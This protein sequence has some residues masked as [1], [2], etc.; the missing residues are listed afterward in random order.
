MSPQPAAATKQ[1]ARAML[2]DVALE[3]LDDLDRVAIDVSTHVSQLQDAPAAL[4][5]STYL[6]VLHRSTS[7]NIGAVMSSL[8]YGID[9][10]SVSPPHGA[11]E[12]VDHVACDR[13]GLPVLLRIYRLGAAQTAHYFLRCL[14]QRVSDTETLAALVLTA[15]KHLDDYVDHVM[16]CLSDQWADRSRE[17][18]R[19]GLHQDAVIRAVIAGDATNIKTLDYPFSGHHVA[20]A[21]RPCT[22]RAATHAQIIASI[23]RRF[24]G[25]PTITLNDHRGSDMVWIAFSDPPPRARIEATV[26]DLASQLFVAASDTAPGVEGF[27]T[28]TLEAQDTM[29]ALVTLKPDGGTATFRRV[30]LMATLLAAPIRARRFAEVVLG[31]LAADT[32]EADRLRI[33]LQAYFA[34]GGSKAGASSRLLVHEK[35]VAY[36]LRQAAKLLGVSIDDNRL[37]LEAALSVWAAIGQERT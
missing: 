31:P 29:G 35:T 26:A 11:L 5:K 19:N 10:T 15:S 37:D 36:R 27:A 23:A 33:T 9:P 32:T 20:L 13:D 18:I 7:A 2:R 8:A 14:G 34:S 1:A 17:A 22:T 21:L 12:L 4:D 16:Q 24:P 25:H 6:E 3:L 30:S 28:V